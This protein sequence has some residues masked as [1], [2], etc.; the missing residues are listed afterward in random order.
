MSSRTT[1]LEKIKQNQPTAISELPNLGTL[2]LESFEILDKYKAVLKG[3]GGDFVEVL[4]YDAII[5]FVKKNYATEKRMITTIPELAEI[6]ATDW[7]NDDPHSLENVELTLVK[8]H[9]GVAENSALW[10]TDDLLG[11]RVSTFIPQYLAI[12]VN[13]KDIVATMHQAYDR[14]GNQEYGFGTFIAGP[15]KTADIEQSLV[16]GAHGARGLTV[17]FMD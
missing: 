4:N 8:A 2:G 3:I 10:V 15:S 6:A 17:F 7:F 16:L 1:I 13:K 9:F 12:V 14:I 11:Q 5:S